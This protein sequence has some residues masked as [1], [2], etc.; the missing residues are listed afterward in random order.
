MA[1]SGALREQYTVIMAGLIISAI[2]MIVLYLLTQKQFIRGL[3]AG[4]LRG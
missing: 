3:A 1:F 4:G 2:P